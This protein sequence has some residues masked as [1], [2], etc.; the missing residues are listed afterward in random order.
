[1]MPTTST[2]RSPLDTLYRWAWRGNRSREREYGLRVPT[3]EQEDR[4]IEEWDTDRD[5]TNIALNVLMVFAYTGTLDDEAIC[6]LA[7]AI[8]RYGDER[9]E[10]A[11]ERYQEQGG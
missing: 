1:M 6:G 4:Y 3:R 2:R 8:K 11:I 7:K 5:S 9:A 10:S